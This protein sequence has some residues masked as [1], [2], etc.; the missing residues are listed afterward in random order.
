MAGQ[1]AGPHRH[2]GFGEQWRRTAGRPAPSSWA[3]TPAEKVGSRVEQRQALGSNVVGA[4]SRPSP[5]TSLHTGGRSQP[6]EDAIEE[7]SE[8]EPEEPLAA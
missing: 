2:P 8:E 3:A 1:R 4:R 7:L 5:S 6:Q